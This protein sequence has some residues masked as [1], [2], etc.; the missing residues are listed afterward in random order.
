MVHKRSP[1]I[2]NH[3][4]PSGFENS[5]TSIP[6]YNS[7]SSSTKGYKK[8]SMFSNIG[9]SFPEI[10]MLSVMKNL[11]ITK[12]GGRLYI[13]NNTGHVKWLV[14]FSLWGLIPSNDSPNRRLFSFSAKYGYIWSTCF[15][16]MEFTTDFIILL[17]LL[18]LKCYFNMLEIIGDWNILWSLGIIGKWRI[19]LAGT[20]LEP[21]T[22]WDLR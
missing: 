13:N 20:I 8:T 7:W 10:R 1:H 16:A 3:L 2:L 19:I 4:C 15:H 11:L 22:K 12:N 6:I 14:L 17:E 9:D 5:S 21:A 18:F